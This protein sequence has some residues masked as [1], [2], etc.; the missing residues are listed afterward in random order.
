[1]NEEFISALEQIAEEKK[2][3][4]E[5]ILE[6]TES[7]LA[8]A[9]RKDYAKPSQTIRCKI[10]PVK[11]TTEFWLEKKIVEEVADEN[12]EI[13]LADAL[14]EDKD[15]VI[16]GVIK[17]PLPTK[18]DFGRIAAQTAKQV[19][20][21][22][23]KEVEREVVFDEYK[24]L[25][26]K[27]LN[28]VVQQIE[29]GNIIVDLG[30]ANG[31]MFPSEQ[32]TGENYRVGQRI[33]VLLLRVEQTNKGP[34]IMVSRA[35]DDV[36]KYLFMIEVPE[37]EAGSVAIMGIAREAGVR[38][39]MSVRALQEGVDPVGSCV[40]QR[41]TRVQAVLGEIGN[42]KID[43]VLWNEEPETYI[44]NALSP[45]KID[46]VKLNKRAKEALVIVNPDQLSL[47]IGKNGQNV[48]LAARL[49][50]WKIDVIEVGSE[51]AKSFKED[52]DE[53]Q[54]KKKV[55]KEESKKKKKNIKEGKEKEPE[56][57]KKE[58]KS[59]TKKKETEK[60]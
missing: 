45:A 36:I 41:G 58:K 19:I 14:K 8:A 3:S 46:S 21:Q 26:G 9:Y 5:S 28:G 38:T 4:K 40:G 11:G 56:K 15:A 12:A 51:A 34:Q 42:E 31:V 32:I 37:I 29:G 18:E 25:E 30:R 49:T 17:Y 33:K 59:A 39:K 2:I 57:N 1:M 53:E 55:K 20:I 6:A 54:E 52:K 22:K 24:T 27:L 7:A 48:R 43:I 50:D 13:L 23:L 35:A 10:D 47:A 60:K 44:A 16:D